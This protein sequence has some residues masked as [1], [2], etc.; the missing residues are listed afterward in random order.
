[1]GISD[2]RARILDVSLLVP[3]WTLFSNPPDFAP[4]PACTLISC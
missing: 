2:P 3:V 1:M 4:N